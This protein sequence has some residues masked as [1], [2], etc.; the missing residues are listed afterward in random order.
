[1]PSPYQKLNDA[2]W[3]RASYWEDGLS[4]SQ[5]ATL[6]G[7]VNFNPAT[8]AKAMRRHGIPRRSISEAKTGRPN[9]NK[10]VPMSAEQRQKMSEAR[11]GKPSP[12]TAEQRQAL[13]VKMKQ[14]KGTSPAA[15]VRAGRRTAR[16]TFR[17][18]TPCTV[19]GAV[20]NLVRHHRNENTSDNSP[21]NIAWLCRSC[22]MRHHAT[23]PAEKWSRKYGDACA[24]CGSNAAPHCSKGYCKPCYMA[25]YWLAHIPGGSLV[26]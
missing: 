1:M 23:L 20:A 8:V 14:I 25:R 5:I 19:C 16:R 17:D 18:P 13:S 9:R 12:L 11:K 3:L 4:M 26:P 21:E 10:G 24:G 15:D 6:V 22:H 7:V 2:A